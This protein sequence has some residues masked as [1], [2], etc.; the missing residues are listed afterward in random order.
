M[1]HNIFI[2]RMYA[3]YIDPDGSLVN[4]ANDG[5]LAVAEVEMNIWEGREKRL[6]VLSKG[7]FWD[8]FERQEVNASLTKKQPGRD[9]LS[10]VDVMNIL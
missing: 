7:D 5:L 4:Y 6:P 8:I 1:M 10:T 2:Q 9:A 3:F